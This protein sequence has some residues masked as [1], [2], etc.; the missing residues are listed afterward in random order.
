MAHRTL[1]A[2]LLVLLLMLLVPALALLTACAAPATPATPAPTPLEAL[3][4]NRPVLLFGEVHDNAIQH[5]ERLR[6]FER[7]LATG[8]RPALA[9]EQLDR[10][11]QPA[12]DALLQRQ[13][14]PTAAEIVAAGAPA[15]PGWN[16]AFYTPFIT[17]ALQHGLPIVAANVSRDESRRVMR[18]GL[19]AS[20][21]TEPVPADVLAAYGREIVDS[22]CGMVD[23]PMAQRM[24]Q[25]QVARDQFMARVLVAHAE[26][27]V[28]LLAGNGHVRTDIGAPRWLPRAVRARSLAIGW[29]E[30]G[31]DD[32][33]AMFDAVRVTPPQPRPD[34]CEG[35]R[36]TIPAKPTRE[37]AR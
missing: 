31:A 29:L 2:L 26:R 30:E 18:E 9:M 33:R 13:P 10:D 17:L 1:P 21:F 4:L 7:L 20:G 25:A 15:G 35:M 14:R 23:A 12:I 6:V 16:W 22:H 32:D 24:A 3:P 34:P 28:V 19:A 27:G 8:A 11:K 37:S 5:A 36:K